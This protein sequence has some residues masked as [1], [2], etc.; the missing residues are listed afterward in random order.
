MASRRQYETSSRQTI[1]YA[2]F[3]GVT[4]GLA[5]SIVSYSRKSEAGQSESLRDG[6]PLQVEANKYTRFPL[7]LLRAC[8]SDKWPSPC[9]DCCNAMQSASTAQDASRRAGLE[10][11]LERMQVHCPANNRSRLH[12]VSSMHWCGAAYCLSFGPA[13]IA[14]RL[15]QGCGLQIMGPSER[16]KLLRRRWNCS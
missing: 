5:I 11:D 1:A 4:F 15:T 6:L 2:V 10:V 12:A 9:P 8:S 13:T 14:Q 3:V 7:L 16:C